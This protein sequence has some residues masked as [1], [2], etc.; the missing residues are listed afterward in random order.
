MSSK[1]RKKASK[2]HDRYLT[3]P[4][5][6]RAAFEQ[7]FE[8]HGE[9][10]YQAEHFLEPGAGPGPFV[11]L[12]PQYFTR[13]KKAIGV[14]LYHKDR[15]SDYE[16]VRTDFL[17]WET[18]L[19]F[20]VVMSNPPYTWAEAFIRKTYEL[21]KPGG[22]ALFLV[23]IGMAGSKKRRPL[24]R[25]VLL[26]ELWL[27]RPRPSFVAAGSSDSAEYAFFMMH[28]PWN[29]HDGGQ[30]TVFRFLDWD[31]PTDGAQDERVERE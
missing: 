13:L 6:V 19:R 26:D 11:S 8:L 3:P 12:A 5:L 15:G 21:L 17:K 4:R 28:R 7:L 30:D 9:R 10:V 14:E 29:K 25:E 2:A 23:R 22:V 16:L 20:D 18:K 27:C 1:N 24:W 31:P